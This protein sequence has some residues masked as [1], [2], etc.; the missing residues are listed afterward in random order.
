M[1]VGRNLFERFGLIGAVGPKNVSL[2][3]IVRIVEPWIR[4]P[5]VRAPR[6]WL[7]APSEREFHRKELARRAFDE[8]LAR[9][10]VAR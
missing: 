3:S 6:V 2:T 8:S 4:K 1:S 7:S 10:H 9:L 5:S